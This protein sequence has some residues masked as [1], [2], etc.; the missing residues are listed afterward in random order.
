MIDLTFMDVAWS[1]ALIVLALVLTF[2]WKIPVQK[3]MAIGSVRAF[4]QLVA[5]GYALKFI[6]ELESPW[7][8]PK[9]QSLLASKSV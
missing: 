1:A 8:S 2:Y 5:I 6:F 9:S 4:V 3:D 7:L